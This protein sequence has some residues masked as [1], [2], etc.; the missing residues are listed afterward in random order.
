MQKSCIALGAG[1]EVVVSAKII[2]KMFP[3]TI[4]LFKFDRYKGIG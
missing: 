1:T 4:L 2:N 3:K